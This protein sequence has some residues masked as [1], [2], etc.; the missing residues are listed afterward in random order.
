MGEVF[1]LEKA[2]YELGHDLA[3]RPEW[4]RFPF[5]G[6]PEILEDSGGER[7]NG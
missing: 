1:M 6:I 2:I 5:R 7:A 3:N 4:V